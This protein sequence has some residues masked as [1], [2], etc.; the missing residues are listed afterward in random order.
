MVPQD[1]IT[2][3]HK[4]AWS[5]SAK[6]SCGHERQLLTSDSKPEALKS[7]LIWRLKIKIISFKIWCP[8]ENKSCWIEQILNYANLW[9]IRAS[10][11]PK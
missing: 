1:D 11:E 10:S 2:K 3:L 5:L 4:W 8:N 7:I 9:K 6:V